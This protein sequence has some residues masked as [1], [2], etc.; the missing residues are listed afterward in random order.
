[1][2]KI[3]FGSENERVPRCFSRKSPRATPSCVH[4][5]IAVRLH[6]IVRTRAQLVRMVFSLSWL[7][8]ILAR[9][10]YMV[11]LR[12]R[13]SKACRPLLYG[14]NFPIF[15]ITTKTQ[16]AKNSS[17]PKNSKNLTYTDGAVK[18]KN[19]LLRGWPKEPVERI[20]SAKFFI[21]LS[22]SPIE[23]SATVW[24]CSFNWLKGAG[25]LGKAFED[26]FDESDSTESK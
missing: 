24:A 5:A 3:I 16:I 6:F 8:H 10:S 9:S 17:D 11:T 26:R 21:F 4:G 2:C 15:C 25:S 20:L 23:R 13:A 14:N 19:D 12:F 22:S 1:M 18:F 7:V